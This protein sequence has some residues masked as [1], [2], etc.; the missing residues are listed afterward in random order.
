M[1]WHKDCTGRLTQYYT[2]AKSRVYSVPSF[3]RFLNTLVDSLL[4]PTIISAT[5]GRRQQKDHLAGTDG[6]YPQ[7]RDRESSSWGSWSGRGFVERGR[8][9]KAE[10]KSKPSGAGQSRKW[11]TGK[12]GGGREGKKRGGAVKNPT[13][14]RGRLFARSASADERRRRGFG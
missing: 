10:P 11:R 7:T 4:K 14:S 3:L 8:K 9:K 2:Q 6:T 13:I 12:P 1:A 5:R